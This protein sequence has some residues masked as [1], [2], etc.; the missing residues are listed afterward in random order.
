M[1]VVD[2]SAL[3]S[4]AVGD[5]LDLVL[6]EFDVI[7]TQTVRDELEATAEYDDRHGNGAAAVLDAENEFTVIETQGDAFESSRIDAGEASCVAVTRSR[8]ASFL[9]TDDYRALPELQQLVNAEVLLSP[10]VLQALVKRGTWSEQQAETAF[11]TIAGERDWLGA[12]IC[13]YARQ[14]FD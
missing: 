13:R 12:S 7:T 3:I 5:A 2:S 14:L 10:I 4:L 8:D 1:V 6:E 11:E 9:V